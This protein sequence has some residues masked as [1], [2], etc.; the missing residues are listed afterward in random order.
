[1]LVL[2]RGQVPEL[3]A[4][5]PSQG[6]IF[7]ITHVS[8]PVFKLSSWVDA[9]LARIAPL[10]LQ[11]KLKTNTS[12]IA[13]D[14][15][16][17]PILA[18]GQNLHDYT[19]LATTAD[20]SGVQPRTTLVERWWMMWHCL[21]NLFGGQSPLPKKTSRQSRQGNGTVTVTGPSIMLPSETQAYQILSNWNSR[22]F[23]V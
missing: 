3:L 16:C 20:I 15:R 23:N 5:P 7:E 1:M 13:F 8:L 12:L 14:T 19:S 11:K 6:V 10:H 18:N 9:S 21:V 4:A 22:S 2:I 17:L